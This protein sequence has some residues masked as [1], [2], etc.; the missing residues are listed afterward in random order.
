MKRV[1]TKNGYNKVDC[2]LWRRVASS[3]RR[4]LCKGKRLKF[5]K[6]RN[7]RIKEFFKKQGPSLKKQVSE[8]KLIFMF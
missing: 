7:I 3:N 8:E 2:L 1:A 4:S 6:E 5:H